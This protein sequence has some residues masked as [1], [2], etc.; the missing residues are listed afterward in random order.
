M[1]PITETDL[2]SDVA[3]SGLIGAVAYYPDALTPVLA[4]LPGTDF[5]SAHR[6][7]VWDA[8]RALSEARDPVE[9]TAVARHLAATGGWNP[10][11]R[12]VVTVEMS[13]AHPATHA[14]AWAATVS[15]L[16]RRRELLR[17][18]KRAHALITDH[19]GDASEALA[20]VRAEFDVIDAGDVDD[21]SGTLT[22]SQLMEEFDREHAPGRKVTAI[23][24]PWPDVDDLIGGLYPGRMY[25]IGGR[26]AAGKST[27]AL[28]VAEHAATEHGKK[29]LIFSREMPTVDVS[30]RI[31]AYGAQVDVS[32]IN[33]RRLASYDRDAIAAYRAKV[34]TPSLRVNARAASL[35]TM[36]ALA[37]A[38][39]HRHGLDVLVVDYLQLVRPDATGRNREQEVARVSMDLKALAMELGIAVVLPAQ[40]NRGPVSRADARPTM[41][42][43][44]D[45]GQIEQDSDVVIL[46]WHQVG[47]DDKPT[48]KVTLLVDKNRH[49]PR[50]EV[51]LAWNGAYGGIG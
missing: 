34:G 8:C 43:L 47:A 39:H 30:G 36:K 22:W 27:A 25:V 18:V 38:Q 51:P 26:P 10:A 24:T 29:V 33:H 49:G 31:L 14:P 48:G 12:R 41:S 2:T 23:P 50:G 9:P 45:S 20:A 3:E 13:A 11:T 21:R 32:K 42:D 7:A 44:R 17:A 19:P 16:A 28:N 1:E 46:L 37:R 6:G 40:L 35:S 5:Y 4:S 15:D